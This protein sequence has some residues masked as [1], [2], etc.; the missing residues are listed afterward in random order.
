MT[1]ALTA[2]GR[3]RLL[4]PVLPEPPDDAEKACYAWR[5]LPFLTTALAASALCMIVSQV[6]MEAGQPVLLIFAGYTAVY[7]K[8]P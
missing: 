4:G 5:S 7:E 3:H 2:R 1:A 8:R 6:R